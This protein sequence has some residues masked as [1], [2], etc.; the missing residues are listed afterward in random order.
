[1]YPLLHHSLTLADELDHEVVLEIKEVIGDHVGLDQLDHHL[2]HA[3]E[4]ALGVGN[5][6][7]ALEAYCDFL[8]RRRDNVLGV[9]L[10]LADGEGVA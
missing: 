3:V 5:V 6:E 8:G 9:F 7:G 1:M 10:S 4:L 2:V